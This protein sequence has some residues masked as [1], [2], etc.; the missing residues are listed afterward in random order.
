MVAA[1]LELSSSPEQIDAQLQNTRTPTIN[2]VDHE[3]NQLINIELT[4][5][6]M[7]GLEKRP[8]YSIVYSFRLSP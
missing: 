2:T 6:M 8:I 5:Q 3:R 7:V 4:P 1:I